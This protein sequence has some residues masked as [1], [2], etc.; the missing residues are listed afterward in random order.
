[1]SDPTDARSPQR[2]SRE[3]LLGLLE[4]AAKTW[5][6]DEGYDP[7]LRDAP[8]L[9]V[10]S[11]PKEA[12]NGLVDL[13][14]ALSYLELFAPAMG[15]GTCWAGLLHGAM[16]ASPS[17]RDVVGIPEPHKHHYPMMLG[18]PAVKYYR[19]PERK[20]PKINFR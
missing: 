14:I 1:M 6:A 16:L 3:E 15:L 10:A 9:I 13:T 5:L 12:I 11:A 19:L 17:L 2:C 18:Y 8:V 4:D 7:V 20:P